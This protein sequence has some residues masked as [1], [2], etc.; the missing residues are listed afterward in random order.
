[1]FCSESFRKKIDLS[2]NECETIPGQVFELFIS[3]LVL[4]ISM[5]FVVQTY[6]IPPHFAETLNKIEK[7]ITIIFLME[8]LLRWWSKG[9]SI[10]YFFTPLAVIDLLAILPLFI[11]ESKWQFVRLLRLFRILRLLRIFKNKGFVFS[12]IQEYHLRIL[13]ILFTLFCIVFISSSLI[14]D[15]EHKVNSENIKTFFDALYFS[16]VTLATVGF[17]DITPVTMQGKAITLMMIVSG[18]ILIPWQLSDLVRSI[19]LTTNK[20]SQ[21]VCKNCHLRFHDFDAKFCKNCGNP[22]N[23]SKKIVE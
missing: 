5:I 1:M 16:I 21:I 15:T 9:C 8:Y 13:K 20:N 2:L 17:G 4:F 22:I 23:P 14:Y 19:V 6:S 3:F 7:S 18:A 10:K 11:L 12:K